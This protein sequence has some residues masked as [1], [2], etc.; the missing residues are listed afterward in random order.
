MC[1]Y[2]K[3]FSFWGHRPPDPLPGL[4]YWALPSP[5]PPDWPMFILG[6]SWGKFRPPPP[7]KKKIRNP[8][9][10]KKTDET[11]EPDARMAG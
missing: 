6:L 8:P 9:P 1:K 11:E 5:E 7:P 4:P 10:P 2:A 3:S